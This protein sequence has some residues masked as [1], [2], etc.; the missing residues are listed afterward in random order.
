M[1]AKLKKNFIVSFFIAVIFVLTPPVQAYVLQ[2]RHVLDLMIARMG[3]AR[4]LFV[5]EKLIYYRVAAPVL[6]PNAV[7]AEDSQ[8]SANTVEG[9]S[10]TEQGLAGNQ[11]AFETEEM[12]LEGSLRFVFSQAFRSDVKSANSERIYISSGGST[13]T[14]VD[15]KIVPSTGNRFDLFKDILLYR[16]R[17]ALSERLLQMGVDVAV[18]S[19]GRFED[20]IAFVIGADYPD[21]TVNQL[22][23]D[24]DT[25]LPLRLILK[26]GNG[27]GDSDTVEIRYLIWWKVGET[28]YPSKIEFYQDDQ[29]VR[30]SQAKN[31]EE[32]PTFSQQ[33][34]DIEHMKRVYP[35][36]PAQPSTPVKPEE[37][38]EIQKTINEFKRIFE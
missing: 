35:P 34:F 16:S 30:V 22:W 15:G 9:H 21:E 20:K 14:V 3:V 7:T 26:G 5:D 38:S 29:L 8:P 11:D 18:T 6:P 24:K 32:N 4:S 13:L 10:R 36:A 28:Q 1:K 17:G 2:G 31:F 37:P 19:L 25:L 33:L 23:V 27:A 12:E